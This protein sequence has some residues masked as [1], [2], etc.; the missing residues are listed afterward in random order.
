MRETFPQ[1]KKET[2]AEWKEE[3]ADAKEPSESF[4][5]SLSL[6]LYIEN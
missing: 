5:P 1:G 6:S 3:E 4:L 2:M